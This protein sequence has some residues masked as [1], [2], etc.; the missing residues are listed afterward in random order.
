MNHL[1]IYHWI[2]KAL[3]GASFEFDPETEQWV[4]WNSQIPGVF[5]QGNTIEETR[6]DL[7]EVLE[8]FLIVSLQRG[9]EI[10]HFDIKTVKKPLAC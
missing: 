9:E 7:I 3:E 8:D 1:K 10:P 6:N 4:A 2:E 5:V